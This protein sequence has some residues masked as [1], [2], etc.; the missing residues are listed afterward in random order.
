MALRDL[1]RARVRR[2]I[3]GGWGVLELAHRGIQC[4]LD[5]V[6]CHGPSDWGK[7]HELARGNNELF[8]FDRLAEIT[9]PDQLEE[10]DCHVLHEPEDHGQIKAFCRWVPAEYAAVLRSHFDHSDS[11]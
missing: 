2:Y 11:D 10:W 3:E 5:L 6:S 7:L 1:G 8:I 9:P 4:A